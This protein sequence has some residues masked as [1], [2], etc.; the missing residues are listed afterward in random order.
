MTF[1][2]QLSGMPNKIMFTGFMEDSLA[3]AKKN[4]QNLALLLLDLDGYGT[5]RERFG[6]EAGEILLNTMA[7]RL[8]ASIR[9][10]DMAAYFGGD[11]FAVALVDPKGVAAAVMAAERIRRNLSAPFLLPEG[12][13]SSVGVSIGIAVYPENG[14]ELDRLLT[15]A[16]SAMFESKTGGKNT[17]TVFKGLTHERADI[18]PWIVL[19]QNDRVGI[20]VLDDQHKKLADLINE[21]HDAISTVPKASRQRAGEMYDELVAFTEKHFSTEARMMKMAGYPAADAHIRAHKFLLDELRYLK[22]RIIDADEVQAFQLLK[23]WLIAHI[24]RDDRPMGDYLK[25]KAG[26]ASQ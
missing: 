10:T 23:D 25:S 22:V 7:E 8:R 20:P 24:E 1:Y 18:I 6:Q 4:N 3:R 15:V 19:G 16:D 13:E 14:T 9:E 26:A 2:D 5:I 17:S 11:T 21:L 12:A